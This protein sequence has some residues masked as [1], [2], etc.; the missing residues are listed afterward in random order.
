M[1]GIF[2][3]SFD[4]DY[5]F[6]EFSKLELDT[7]TA[8]SGKVNEAIRTDRKSR[9]RT[10]SRYRD[11]HSKH[12]R[13]DEYKERCHKRDKPTQ[14]QLPSSRRSSSA[15]SSSSSD[16]RQAVGSRPRP[17][18][19]SIL[20]HAKSTKRSRSRSHSPHD[21]S[22]SDKRGRHDNQKQGGKAGERYAS[23]QVSN[24]TFR[25]QRIEGFLE[26]IATHMRLSSQVSVDAEPGPG[27][28]PQRPWP[29]LGPHHDGALLKRSLDLG[30]RRDNDEVSLLASDK[31][32]QIR[33]K[34]GRT[35]RKYAST[36]SQM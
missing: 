3:T 31:V 6:L 32:L 4:S 13:D 21:K 35:C 23:E 28:K 22:R 29:T 19:S 17:T 30:R 27:S 11:P 36:L 15:S 10:R 1:E 24:L 12:G 25:V 7:D 16:N 8:G 33:H 26:Q 34:R 2:S 18:T 5:H 9:S 20:Y 14:E